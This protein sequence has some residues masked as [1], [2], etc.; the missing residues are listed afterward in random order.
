MLT[1][2]Q[3]R[4]ISLKYVNIAQRSAFKRGGDLEF[5]V[6]N[7][8]YVTC[9]LKHILNNFVPI[10]KHNINFTLFILMGDGTLLCLLLSFHASVLG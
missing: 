10:Q 8:I 9:S 3:K 4:L 5:Y 7:N 6:S 1:F 2:T